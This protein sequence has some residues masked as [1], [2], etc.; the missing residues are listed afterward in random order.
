MKQ[1]KKRTNGRNIIL[2]G[3]PGTGKSHSVKDIIKQD[4]AKCKIEIEDELIENLSD[5]IAIRTTFHP[6]SDYS[7]FIGCYKPIQHPHDDKIIVYDFTPQAFINAYV[8]AWCTN[9]PYYLIIDEINRGNCAQIFGDVFQIIDRQPNG[10]HEYEIKADSDLE[11][12]LKRAFNANKSKIADNE[13]SV[14]EAIADGKLLFLPKNLSLIATMN[15]SDQSLFP[16]DSAFKRRWEWCY[17]PIQNYPEVNRRIEIDGESYDWYDFITKVNERIESVTESDDKQLGYWF[18]KTEEGK[19]ITASLFVSKVVFY[20]WMD[21]FK[22]MGK[23][24]NSP[25]TIHPEDDTQEAKYYKFKD[26]TS[27]NSQSVN[28]NVVKEFLA[29]LKVKT[30][31]QNEESNGEEDVTENPDTVQ[32]ERTE[33]TNETT[34]VCDFGDGTPAIGDAYSDAAEVYRQALEKVI[35]DGHFDELIQQNNT[36]TGSQRLVKADELTNTS[37]YK[38]LSNGW[39]AKLDGNTKTKA[40]RLKRIADYEWYPNYTVTTIPKLRRIENSN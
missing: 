31:E 1:D 3:A 37:G 15:T 4:Y 17:V 35:S 25:F 9:N 21:V 36:L 24:D 6:D 16:M 34:I 26:F 13:C 27:V 5:D 20:L 11:K 7:S 10:E 32:N 18:V 19:P 40:G 38:M 23:H 22:D 30:W 8:N 14:P 12:Y 39:A 29:G 2:F 33:Q 28:T